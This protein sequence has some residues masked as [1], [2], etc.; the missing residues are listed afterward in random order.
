MRRLA[1][2]FCLATGCATTQSA[3]PE[4]AAQ[5]APAQPS[6]ATSSAQTPAP[7]ATTP[8]A[9]DKAEPFSMEEA[10]ARE[11]APLPKQRLAP[12]EGNFIGEVEGSGTP[13][14]ERSEG[15]TSIRVPLADA[16]ELMC[17]V[18]DN[19]IDAGGALLTVAQA[20]SGDENLQ[21]QRVSPTDIVESGGVPA[22][23]LDVDYLTPGEGGMLAGQ[24]KLMVRAA[25]EL[26]LLC[27]HDQP[28]YVQSFRR[29]TLA[30]AASLAVPGQPPPSAPRYAEIQVVR[31]GKHPVGF[32]WWVVQDTD[33]GKR[34]TENTRMLMLPRTPTE[35]VVEDST[36]LATS[37]AKGQLL[38]VSHAK[39]RGGTLAM[40]VTLKREA[41]GTYRYEGI[42][43]GKQVAGTFESKRGIVHELDTAAAVR[44]RL[45]TG[46]A[47]EVTF[48]VYRP[49]QDPTKPQQVVY[50]KAEGAPRGI[51]VTLGTTVYTGTADARG[52]LEHAEMALPG[53]QVSVTVDRLFAR[54]EP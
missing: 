19:T 15:T 13:I 39:A 52:L 21:V 54:G 1:I 18:Y 4:E 5:A 49:A 25:N 43:E 37:D 36:F 20:I 51:T 34:V 3:R 8:A 6:T 12:P 32:E 31:L 47:K 17:F 22:V 27:A 30:L 14:Y 45:L 28:G 42:H 26:P 29:I 48:D 7:A 16:S 2:L 23:F 33:D 35:L 24:V 53:N 38:E 41:A 40:Q 50:R 9:A 46:K 10:R 11:L 44:E